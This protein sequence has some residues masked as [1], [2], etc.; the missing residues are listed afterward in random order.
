[1]TERWPW[2]VIGILIGE[3]LRRLAFVIREWWYR[4]EA[5]GWEREAEQRV[6]IG[7]E[8]VDEYRRSVAALPNDQGCCPFVRSGGLHGQDCADL[9]RGRCA[10][11][12][13]GP[14]TFEAPEPPKGAA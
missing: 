4:T 12:Q 9:G 3:A 1:V 10:W 11:V 8:L 7:N 2:V 14:N 6:R 5:L 13:L